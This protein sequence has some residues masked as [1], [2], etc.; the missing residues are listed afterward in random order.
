MRIG[1]VES[2]PLV[3]T[4]RIFDTT[5]RDGE[6]SPGAAMSKD[7]KLRI[8]IQLE[9]LGVDVI[10]AGFAAASPGEALAI[11]NVSKNIKNVTVCSLARANES[12]IRIAADAIKDARYP[13]LHTFIASSPIHMQHKLKMTESEVLLAAVKAVKLAASFTDDVEFSAE[14][15]TRSDVNFLV[16]LITEVIDAGATTI[17]L[18]DTVGYALPHQ[19]YEMFKEVISRVNPP[20]EVV[21]STHCHN[22]LGLAVANSLSA[23][24]AGARQVECTINGLGERAGN[25]ALEEVVMA[26]KTRNDSLKYRTNIRSQ[27]LVPLSKLV[28]GV[29][30]YTVQAN[31]AIVGANAFSHESGI[32]QDGVLKY[33]QTYEIMSAEQVGWASNRLTLGKLSGRKGLKNKL[34]QLGITLTDGELDKLFA[35]FKELADVKSKIFDEDIQA[36]LSEE[37]QEGNGLELVSVDARIKTGEKPF[38]EVVIMD[39]GRRI[40][41]SSDGDGVIDSVFKAIE[42]FADSGSK[43]TL[44]SVNAITEGHDAQ[45]KVLVRLEKDGRIF[46][47][48]GVDPDI[49]IA[50]AKAYVS[51]LNRLEIREERLKAQ[52]V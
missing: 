11:K 28:S 39:G 33:R 47:G 50:S 37:L 14:D 30:G 32:H 7:E 19:I 44:Y 22:D 17:N 24:L 25:A 43:M 35:R 41:T 21:F 12:E 6:Q 49:I 9:N 34:D 42:K 2:F 46:N 26:I 40:S 1:L 36:L 45:G 52:G 8:A 31:K 29:T 48:T 38:A 51:A 5:L 13:R 4:V 15:A 16:R 10:E 3:D 20:P 23:I 18:P 27:L